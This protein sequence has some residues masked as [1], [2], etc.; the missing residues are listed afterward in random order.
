MLWR[1]FQLMK[2]NGHCL[3]FLP[4]SLPLYKSALHSLHFGALHLT[5]AGLKPW[6]A[7][8]CWTQINSS[9]L[10]KYLTVSLFQVNRE[11]GINMIREAKEDSER[12]I[13][14]LT[15]LKRHRLISPH[16]WEAGLEKP[17]KSRI[18]YRRS[19]C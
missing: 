13:I 1:V 10:E 3:T 5:N 17:P 19:I 18:N 8:L 15:H 2:R 7:I 4:P 6:T 16:W 9:L 14:R 11:K 12:Q